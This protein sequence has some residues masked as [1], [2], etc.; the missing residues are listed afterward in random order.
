MFP[1]TGKQETDRNACPTYP[2]PGFFV[3]A[4]YKGVS[5]SVRTGQKLA[6]NGVPHPPVFFV[7]VAKKGVRETVESRKV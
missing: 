6:L 3:S 4:D 1:L 7:R 2:P 5:G